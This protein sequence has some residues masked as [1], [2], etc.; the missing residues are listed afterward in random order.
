MNQLRQIFW[1]IIIAR[2]V[3]NKTIIPNQNSNQ[4]KP[5]FEQKICPENIALSKVEQGAH[6]CVVVHSEDKKSLDI[7][8]TKTQ[9]ELDKNMR[10][11][12]EKS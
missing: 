11:Q 2:I 3:N 10:L 1:K 9:N 4:T 12:Q 8:K 7:L 5:I 6:G